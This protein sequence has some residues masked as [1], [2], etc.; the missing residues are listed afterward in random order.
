MWSLERVRLSKK[1]IDEKKVKMEDY[2]LHPILNQH[3]IYTY[4]ASGENSVAVIN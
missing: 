3:T 1:L 2:M 4:F